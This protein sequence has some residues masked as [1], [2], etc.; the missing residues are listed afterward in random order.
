MNSKSYVYRLTPCPVCDIY[1]TERWLE[2]MAKQGY[3][4]TADGFLPFVTRFERTAPSETR[5]SLQAEVPSKWL[6]RATDR[7]PSDE[8]LELNE[9]SGWT[10]V[11]RRG[12]FYIFSADSSAVEAHTDPIVEEIAISHAAKNQRANLIVALF[13]VLYFLLLRVGFALIVAE[14]GIVFTIFT[15]IVVVEW[16][17]GLLSNVIHYHRLR[18]QLKRGDSSAQK[19]SVHLTYKRYIAL[20]LISTTLTVCWLVTVATM[21]L[22][23]EQAIPLTDYTSP[24]PFATMEQLSP[25]AEFT[26]KTVATGNNTIEVKTDILVPLQ[27]SLNEH[28]QYTTDRGSFSG[29]VIFDYYETISPTFAE[30]LASDLLVNDKRSAL[31]EHTELPTFPT[32]ADTLYIYRDLFPTFIIV[33]DS[34]V[35]KAMVYGFTE[36]ELPLERIVNIVADS[37]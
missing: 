28:G 1:G 15:A 18:K 13:W 17:V 11:A 20:K 36:E 29:G 5:Y 24:I 14:V 25:N 10:Y 3:Q 27:I 21:W 33:K 22:S 26:H 30:A 32:T 12:D 16:L 37:L 6:F 34:T 8:F 9:S 31:R 4:L 35:I 19:K 2:D 7:E 23:V